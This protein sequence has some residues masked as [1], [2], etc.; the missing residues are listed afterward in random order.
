MQ[1]STSTTERVTVDWD[2][3]RAQF[4]VIRKEE[5]SLTFDQII[6]GE[7]GDLDKT[8]AYA[9]RLALTLP[10]SSHGHGFVNG[11]HYEMNDVSAFALFVPPTMT[12]G[13]F[14]CIALLAQYASRSRAAAAV[15]TRSCKCPFWCLW[16]R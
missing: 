3:A 6:N 2:V 16:T 13:P 10:E 9:E 7:V 11:K 5:E 15:L 8:R 12:S 1:L 14:Y 4:D